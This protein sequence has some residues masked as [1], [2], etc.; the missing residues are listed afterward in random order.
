ME[1]AQGSTPFH[2]W[3]GTLLVIMMFL[4]AVIQSLSQSHNM[5]KCQKVG[6]KVRAAVMVAVYKKVTAQP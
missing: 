1:V 4:S 2:A 5:L 6:M 3:W